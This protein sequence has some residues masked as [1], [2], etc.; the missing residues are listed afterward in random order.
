[1]FLAVTEIPSHMEPFRHKASLL[2]QAIDPEIHRRIPSIGKEY[3]FV[4]SGTN[5]LDIYRER[6]RCLKIL[7]SEF[8]FFDYGKG[9]PPD[10]YIMCLNTAR[11][12]FI[13]SG[14]TPVANA[15]TAQR[16][17]EC[18]AIGPVLT[19]WTEDLQ[20]LGLVEGEDYYSY[21]DDTEMILK[22]TKLI[23]DPEFAEHMAESGRRKGLM[24][25]TYEH[26]LMS[27]LNSARKYGLIVP[28]TP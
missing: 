25:H 12:Q 8:T 21:K 28:R 19:D 24:Y 9:M 16:F 26:R 5:G 11:V 6:E 13:R 20:H 3:D 18:L 7:K 1:M 15:P 27:I 10:K 22:M 23:R 2:Y 4:F 14:K 17:F